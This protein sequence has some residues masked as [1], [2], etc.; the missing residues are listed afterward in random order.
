MVEGDLVD[1][2]IMRTQNYFAMPNKMFL[3]CVYPTEMV[4]QSCGYAKFTSW[5][6]KFSS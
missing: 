6:G 1:R 5:L 4:S 2:K 3:T